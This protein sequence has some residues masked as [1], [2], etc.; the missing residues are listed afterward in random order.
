MKR[1][2]VIIGDKVN[3]TD[4]A[5]YVQ[6]LIRDA[7]KEGKLFKIYDEEFGIEVDEFIIKEDIKYERVSLKYKMH[8]YNRRRGK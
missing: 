4:S 1:Y 8:K 2:K 5:I 6:Q 3:K 7:K